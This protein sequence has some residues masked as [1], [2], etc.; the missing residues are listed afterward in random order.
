ME[1]QPPKQIY[2]QAYDSDSYDDNTWCVDRI[3]DEDIEYILQSEYDQLKSENEKLKEALEK[4]Y[5][6]Y[7]QEEYHLTALKMAKVAQQALKEVKE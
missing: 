4:I 5:R 2:L 1:K 6:L 7:V 3:N